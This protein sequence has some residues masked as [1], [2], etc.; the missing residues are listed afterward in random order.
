MAGRH[1]RQSG[2]VLAHAADHVVEL[3][4]RGRIVRPARMNVAALKRR[5]VDRFSLI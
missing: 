5:Q 4:G 3:R 1:P 2:K